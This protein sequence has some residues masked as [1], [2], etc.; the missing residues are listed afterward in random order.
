M[1]VADDWQAEFT[2]LIHIGVVDLGFEAYSGRL[3]WI[4]TWKIYLNPEGSFTVW[5]IILGIRTGT[6]M[7]HSRKLGN[8]VFLPDQTKELKMSAPS[9]M[10]NK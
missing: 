5:R 7:I 8:A 3:E 4:L 6:S 10:V 2:L 1:F 9:Q